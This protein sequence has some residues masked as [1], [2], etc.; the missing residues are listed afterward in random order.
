MNEKIYG[1]YVLASVVKLVK[2]SSK[3]ERQ[4]GKERVTQVDQKWHSEV[5]PILVQLVAKLTNILLSVCCF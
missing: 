1:M 3:Y 2:V 4:C 5:I